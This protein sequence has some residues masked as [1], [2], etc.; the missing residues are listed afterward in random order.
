MSSVDGPGKGDGQ[1]AYRRLG[2]SRTDGDRE[3]NRRDAGAE[4]LR[5]DKR[6]GRPSIPEQQ[7][8]GVLATLGE[9]YGVDYVREHKIT[10]YDGWYVTHVDFAWPENRLVIEVYG[11]PHYKTFFDPDGDRD[12]KEARRIKAIE[13]VGWEVLI[14]HDYDM[15]EKT[16]LDSVEKVRDF[17]NAQRGWWPGQEG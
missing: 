11:G 1:Q 14:V 15:K 3:R 2:T 5:A 17:L 8:L 16:W 12:S 9:Q 4:D 10:A 7:M 6:R 13:S